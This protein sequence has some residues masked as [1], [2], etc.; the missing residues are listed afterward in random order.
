[1]ARV[2]MRTKEGKNTKG[3]DPREDADK[4]QH[5]LREALA[6]PIRGEALA[7]G[8]LAEHLLKLRLRVAVVGEEADVNRR[9]L[10]EVELGVLVVHINAH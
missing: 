3:D 4:V 2:K 10:R 9:A 6:D 7:K 5:R 8:A 1:M